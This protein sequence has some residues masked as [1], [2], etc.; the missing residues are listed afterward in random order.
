MRD[1]RWTSQ[2]RQTVPEIGTFALRIVEPKWGER[3]F[4]IMRQE[5]GLAPIFFKN[6]SMDQGRP[7]NFSMD[8]ET[9][10]PEPRA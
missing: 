5:G 8:S 3:K 7:R 6:G 9:S 1:C 2:V 10:R 4:A